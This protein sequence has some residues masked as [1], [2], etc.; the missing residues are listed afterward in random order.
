MPALPYRIRG[1]PYR[2]PVEGVIDNL[3]KRKGPQ[4]LKE[5]HKELSPLEAHDPNAK[6]VKHHAIWSWPAGG[7]W[8]NFHPTA[9]RLLEESYID[10][11]RVCRIWDTA[12][13]GGVMLREFDLDNKLVMPGFRQL[14]REFQS[15]FPP[16]QPVPEVVRPKYEGGPIKPS[17]CFKWRVGKTGNQRK[18]AATPPA[19]ENQSDRFAAMAYWAGLAPKEVEKPATP[20]VFHRPSITKLPDR[21]QTQEPPTPKSALSLTPTSKLNNSAKHVSFGGRSSVAAQ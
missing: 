3:D 8:T 19:V 5:L 10:G 17:Q 2:P 12:Q 14:R 21:S 13:G 7:A 16:V 4:R 18:Y 9:N 15:E 20:K 1:D 11:E 6:E